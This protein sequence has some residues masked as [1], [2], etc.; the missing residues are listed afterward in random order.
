MK[1]NSSTFQ[2]RFEFTKT[3]VMG[4]GCHME[5]SRELNGS[6]GEMTVQAIEEKDQTMLLLFDDDDTS[7]KNAGDKF[8]EYKVGMEYADSGWKNKK[9]FIANRDDRS[10][11]S[12]RYV[13]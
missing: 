5:M 12:F 3:L 11:A 10:F 7:T 1:F 2:A 4:F 6:W 9:V 13:Y 8:E